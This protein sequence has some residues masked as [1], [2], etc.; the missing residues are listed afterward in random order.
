MQITLE[1]SDQHEE[2][3][4]PY[5]LII[6]PMQMLK[7]SADSV[8]DMIR[9]PFFSR[10]EAQVAMSKDMDDYSDRV[11][12]VCVSGS[13][14]EQYKQKWREEYGKQFRIKLEGGS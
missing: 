6:D 11:K 8:A 13:R 4:S 14:T 10:E 7:P 12:V 5:W 3:E 1:I 9:G 2:I